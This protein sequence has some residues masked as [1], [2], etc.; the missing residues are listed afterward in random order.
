MAADSA[1]FTLDK[2]HEK[3]SA[4]YEWLKYN[5]K[6]SQKHQKQE[7]CSALLDIAHIAQCLQNMGIDYDEN[8]FAAIGKC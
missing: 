8:A 5:M 7:K 1:N 4:R 3:A 6:A 2:M